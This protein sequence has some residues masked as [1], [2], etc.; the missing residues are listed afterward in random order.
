MPYEVISPQHES[1]TKN[2]KIVDL[3][4]DT[5]S[6]PTPEMRNAMAKAIVGDDVYGEDPTVNELEQKSAA[7]LNKEAG[8]FLPS[9]TMANLVAIMVHCNQRGSEILVGDNS[10]TFRFEQG[11]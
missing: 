6:K 3:R 9:G 5:L 10:H 8:L 4:S 11:T 1:N 2:I 7:L